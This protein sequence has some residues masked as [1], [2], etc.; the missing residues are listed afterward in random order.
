MNFLTLAS[1]ALASAVVNAADSSKIATDVTA[2]VGSEA[3][4]EQYSTA[5][6]NYSDFYSYFYNTNDHYPTYT[7]G[8][9]TDYFGKYPALSSWM[10]NYNSLVAANPSSAAEI[11]S[12]L[13]EQSVY[14]AWIHQWSAVSTTS[15]GSGSATKS[16]SEVSK[17][18]DSSSG[19]ATDLAH[20]TSG[21][22][23]S[24]SGSKS[25]ASSSGASS[26]STTSSKNMGAGVYAPAGLLVGAVAVALL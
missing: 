16:S 13:Q 20:I 8:D 24:S 21:A 2:S 19:S 3:L 7:V 10:T 15:S 9:F 17:T 11:A 22:S 14:S 1:I 4:W 26:S 23:A 5:F 18:E 12:S 25:G 6:D